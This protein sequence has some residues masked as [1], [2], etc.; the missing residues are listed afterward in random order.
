MSK[1]KRVG[2]FL[3]SMPIPPGATVKDVQS[4]I[5]DAVGAWGGGLRPP[6]CHSN[7]DPGDPLFGTR[8][9]EVKVEL[10]RAP[11]NAR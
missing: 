7:E 4:F 10:K 6:G 3:V 2:Y 9:G 11:R 8:H 5:H 1:R